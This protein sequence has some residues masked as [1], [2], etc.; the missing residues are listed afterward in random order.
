MHYPPAKCLSV[1][2]VWSLVRCRRRK[3]HLPRNHQGCGTLLIWS[4]AGLSTI[5]QPCRFWY[6]LLPY[7]P[8]LT[9]CYCCSAVVEIIIVIVVIVELCCRLQYVHASTG[10]P[11]L[12][13]NLQAM[14]L[15]FYDEIF[16]KIQ[17]YICVLEM[18]DKRLMT[19]KTMYQKHIVCFNLHP[20]A[21]VK[22]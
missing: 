1:W 7:S 10:M 17:N 20:Y 18:K 3:V 14:G 9:C 4:W 16:Y 13:Q 19:V 21:H 8:T 11:T 2:N 5:P 6:E 15:H 12:T 22:A